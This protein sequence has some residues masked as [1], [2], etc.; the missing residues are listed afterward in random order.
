MSA[1]RRGGDA[2]GIESDSDDKADGGGGGAAA[3][4]PSVLSLR[5][6]GFLEAARDSEEGYNAAAA[7]FEA[8]VVETTRS[9]SG[10]E[11]ADLLNLARCLC[12]ASRWDEA[13][14]VLKQFRTRLPAG[15]FSLDALYL[16]G[17][18]HLGTRE[19]REAADVLRRVVEAAPDVEAAHYQLAAALVEAKDDAAAADAY[20]ALLKLR[21]QHRG[22]LYNLAAA[23]RRMGKAA[24][25]ERWEA[26]FLKVQKAEGEGK[27]PQ[28]SDYR[29]CRFTR[30]SLVPP[31]RTTVEPPPNPI[32]W[33]TRPLAEIIEGDG[34]AALARLGAVE[35]VVPL[36]Q[37]QE[38][39]LLVLGSQ[40]SAIFALQEGRLRDISA[41]SPELQA[42]RSAAAA[43]CNNDRFVDFCLVDATGTGRLFRGLGEG[44]F[45]VH[46]ESGLEMEGSVAC[47]WVDYDHDGDLDLASLER[48]GESPTMLKPCLYRNDG[49]AAFERFDDLLPGTVEGPPHEPGVAA[50]WSWA[51]AVG[52]FDLG[53]DIDFA[54]PDAAG[55]AVLF[56]NQ[57]RG[58]FRRQTI[59]GLRGHA[60]IFAADFDNDGDTDLFG[61][62][63]EFGSS[64]KGQ[65]LRVARNEGVGEDGGLRGFRVEDHAEI[66][67]PWDPGSIAWTAVDLDNDG[68]V[69]LAGAEPGFGLHLSNR[70]GATRFERT[71][72]RLPKTGKSRRVVRPIDLQGDGGLQLLVIS[73]SSPPY[74]WDF[75][76]PLAYRAATL[77]LVGGRDNRDG[78]GAHVEVFAKGVYQRLLVEEPGG[79]RI[80]LG[81]VRPE[82]IDGL[83]V[84]WPN[85]VR[86]P[87]F[88]ADLKWDAQ[89]SAQV[90]QKAGLQVSCPFLYGHDGRRW[91]FL[92]DV[93]GIAPLDE[94]VPPNK[95]PHLD[96][97]EW[98]RIPG[99]AL[100]C[101]GGRLRL[102]VTEELR[103][104][105][106]L[107]SLELVRVR[108]PRGVA[109]YADEST[110]QGG[111]EPL[112]VFLVDEGALQPPA[113]L[114]SNSGEDGLAAASAID[115]TYFHGYRESRPQWAGW[116]E[117]FHLDIEL[118]GFSMAASSGSGASPALL[119]TGRIAWQDSG[120]AYA[121]HQ[122]GRSW[123]P[124]RL[125]VLD[126]SGAVLAALDDAGFPCGMDR[127]L[128]VPLGGL[129]RPGA[130]SLRLSATSRLFWDR[131][132]L[133]PQ[134]VEVELG[135]S[136]ERTVSFSGKTVTLFR[137]RLALQAADL[138]YHGYSRLRGDH[139]RHEQTYDIEDAGP[140]REFPS[141]EG[142]ATRYGPVKDLVT[143]SDD[144]LAVLVPGDGLLLEFDCGP[145][146]PADGG[147]TYF[148]RVAGWAKESGFHNRTGRTVEPLP[149]RAMGSYPEGAR[150]PPRT[151]TYDE[152][153]R[154]Y[155][156]R[157]VEAW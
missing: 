149:F 98:V 47:R 131:V 72:C 24:E 56:L 2:S 13:Q 44:M 93:V 121:L 39:M 12:M 142:L 126:A 16:E 153:L 84:L 54:F 146:V 152:Y 118:D 92:T 94:W 3:K 22:A 76:H 41:S 20:L 19:P 103:E 127:T 45:E 85:G 138:R 139:A 30:V 25:R 60:R 89:H 79:L 115:G 109:V 113:S 40:A 33:T 96:P 86:Q 123:S 104:T 4:S 23:Y 97:E 77:R 117:P 119:L 150:R 26:E 9:G 90:T 55:D 74:S 11:P 147:W 110:R 17:L 38:T 50:G 101:T 34:A 53:N 49:V 106:Y 128:V 21:P 120:V 145:P 6:R 148:L 42:G 124:H 58:P 51:F 18:V 68:D 48:R 114:R 87:V 52:D 140:L 59:P 62:P 61:A 63:G 107:D 71:F 29:R 69:D 5:N 102:A 136:G 112:R 1:C 111:V 129:L 81:D 132:A 31:A 70:D 95:S 7:A 144:L 91:R 35:D 122:H 43:D 125:E 100:G 10:A 88:P 108:H 14:K 28:E 137:E 8:C 65:P 15:S 27:A 80:G 78:I 75:R 116:V 135:A 57:R 83:L 64:S 32:A 66:L 82:E 156:R 141:P 151:A 154:T 155:Q 143:E 37:A 99:A 105:T 73:P 67:I 133:A 46:R 36:R 134:A 130:R 157:K